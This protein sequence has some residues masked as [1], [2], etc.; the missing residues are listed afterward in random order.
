MKKSKNQKKRKTIRKKRRTSTWKKEENKKTNNEN[1]YETKIIKK[2]NVLTTIIDKTET[3]TDIL[4]DKSYNITQLTR[5]KIVSVNQEGFPS[6]GILTFIISI[7]GEVP[8]LNQF[9]LPLINPEEIILS[10]QL[11][12]IKLK[13]QSDRI[14]N[15][16][17]VSIEEAIKEEENKDLFIIENFSSKDII[18]YTN[19]LVKRTK[20]KLSNNIFFRQVSHFKKDDNLNQIFFNLITI[21]SEKSSSGYNVELKM[22]VTINKKNNE[23]IAICILDKDVSPNNGEFV[24]VNFLC[25]INLTSSEYINTDFEKIAIST[26][27]D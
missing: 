7:I 12:G 2:I 9:T 10:C 16:N 19:A 15:Q 13:Y 21:V 26:V 3:L 23:K 4:S 8:D 6:S 1:T 11:K 27:N 20:E 14:I 22:N 18:N 25:S 5:L 17:L 24:Q